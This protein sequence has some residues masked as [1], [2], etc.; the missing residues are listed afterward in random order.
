MVRRMHRRALRYLTTT[1]RLSISSS[2]NSRPGVAEKSPPASDRA[3]VTYAVGR[4][5]RPGGECAP[6]ALGVEQEQ[7]VLL[8]LLD[9]I[10]FPIV[11]FLG[12]NKGG[13]RS[14]PGR[15][16]RLRFLAARQPCPRARRLGRPLRMRPDISE[17]AGPQSCDYLPR[18][19]DGGAAASV[20]TTGRG[21]PPCRAGGD[22]RG[23]HLLPALL[24]GTDR[25]AKGRGTSALEPNPH[26]R[27]PGDADGAAEART[28]L[29]RAA[30][31]GRNRARSRAC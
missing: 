27:A 14:D 3:S 16:P 4:A 18:A 24:F 1:T 5:N 8:C 17:A 7:R 26:G 25:N 20:P 15:Y 29:Y 13:N 6:R 28:S 19:G 31:I 12:R 2:G 21:A 23:R 30:R 11:L 10:D 22:D 9:R